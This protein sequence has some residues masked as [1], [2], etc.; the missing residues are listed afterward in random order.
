M[1]GIVHYRTCHQSYTQMD[2]KIKSCLTTNKHN[3]TFQYIRKSVLMNKQYL[4]SQWV[5]RSEWQQRVQIINTAQLY[6]TCKLLCCKTYLIHVHK[7]Q[8]W[9]QYA[10]FK[11]KCHTLKEIFSCETWDNNLS[12][13][14]Y[15]NST[16]M[17]VICVL[18]TSTMTN[19][20]EM[21]TFRFQ[22]LC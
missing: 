15:K 9:W 20:A 13:T 19:K 2:V 22:T 21:T 14:V 11:G 6:C 18:I 10:S 3:A 1:Y 16:N 7:D 17:A 12:L 8:L 5:V 4:L